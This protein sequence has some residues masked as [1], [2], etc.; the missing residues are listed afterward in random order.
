MFGEFNLIEKYFSD[1]QPQRKDVHLALGDDCAILHVPNHVRIAISTDTLVAGT[2]FL[3]DAN[4]AWV[5]H[6]ALASNISDLAAMGATPAW[7]SMALT[8]PSIDERWLAPFCTAFFELAN[9]YNV[10]LIGGDTTK[11]PLA[12]TL[13]VQGFIPQ[14][15]ALLRDQAKVGDWIYVTGELG[16]SKAGLD[17]ILDPKKREHPFAAELERRHYLS[18]PRVLVGQALLNIASSAIDISDGLMA[19]LGHILHRSQVG[20]SIDVNALPLSKELKQ[21]VGEL[22]L[23]Q[24]YALTS[25][26]EYELCFTVPE[27]NRGALESALAHTACKVTCI[28][29]IRP[30]GIIE[31]TRQGKKLDW[32]LMGYDHFKEPV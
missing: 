27:E 21:F 7:V 25:G 8:L 20:A 29:Q 23:A 24:Q 28:G 6:K 16:D 32:S 26:E 2:H 1:R 9:Y 18:T 19:D 4:P 22:S 5:A 31:L 17:V 30:Q 12:I 11:G 3:A 13:T 10:Q 14:D 15:K